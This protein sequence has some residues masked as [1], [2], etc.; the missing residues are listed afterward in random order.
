VRTAGTVRVA[1]RVT[2]QFR[3]GRVRTPGP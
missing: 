1:D 3:R 2:F